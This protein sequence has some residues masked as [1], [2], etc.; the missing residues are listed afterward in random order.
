MAYI[1]HIRA[2]NRW[3]PE[4]FLPLIVDGK[5]MGRI[6]HRFAQELDGFKECF[7]VRTECVVLSS[8]LKSF[9]ERSEAVA[10]VLHR[11]TESGVVR[12]LMGEM[13]P[14]LSGFDQSAAFQIDRAVVSMF[15]IRAFGQHLNGYVETGDGIAMWIARRASDRRA[16]PDR[17]DHL[18]AGGLPHGISLADNLTKECMEEANIPAELAASARPVAEISYCCEV[19]RGLR[20][21]TLFCYDLELPGSFRPECNDG[22]VASFELMPIEQVADIVRN[23]EEFKPNCNL[24][25]I[26]FLLRHNLIASEDERKLLQNGL[27]GNN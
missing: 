16:F 10:E 3:N 14:V 6:R 7:D 20:D 2:L 4:N 19:K 11:L 15:G 18:V 12:H 27:S 26:D 23:S 1:D 8:A 21:D 22:E 25:I 17:L 9:D 13:F 5:R 24:V